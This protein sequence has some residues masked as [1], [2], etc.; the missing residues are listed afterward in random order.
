MTAYVALMRGINVGTAKQIKMP[1]L[2]DVFTELGLDDPQTLLRSGNV[3]FRSSQTLDAAYADHIEAAVL[4]ATG[5]Q[6]SVVLFDESEF[7]RIASEDPLQQI[8]TDP[9]RH[10]IGFSSV[11][12]EN[13]DS[14]SMPSAK[15]IAPELI[16]VGR[17][18]IYQ[19]CP[20]GISKSKV[21]P[22]F[23]KQFDG[24]ITTRNRRTVDKLLA[25]IG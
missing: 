24:V 12:I 11:P 18:A 6:S 15:D 4:E 3:V 25:M 17:Q 1:A 20:D 10:V 14:I 13:P 16:V 19:W 21:K 5:V 7:T 9:A 8:A 23:W 22:G 2:K